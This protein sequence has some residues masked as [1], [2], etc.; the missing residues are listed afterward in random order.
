[1]GVDPAVLSYQ[2]AGVF[3]FNHLSAMLMLFVQF[4]SVILVAVLLL[5]DVID[6]FVTLQELIWSQ[7]SSIKRWKP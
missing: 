7:R 6:L 3:S 4:F 2:L 5:V 1:M